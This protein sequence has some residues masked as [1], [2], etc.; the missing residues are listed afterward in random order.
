MSV[1]GGAG[2]GCARTLLATRYERLTVSSNKLNK[3]CFKHRSFNVPYNPLV[4]V[5]P[6]MRADNHKY[7]C[8]L[9]H[10]C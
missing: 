7:F 9:Y 8:N 10:C 2:C 6:L 4:L 5:V 1:G 3:A